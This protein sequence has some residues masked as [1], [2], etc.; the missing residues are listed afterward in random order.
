MNYNN[1]L[2]L[3]KTRIN[4]I[5]GSAQTYCVHYPRLVWLRKTNSGVLWA[6]YQPRGFPVAFVLALCQYQ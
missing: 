3:S 6:A 5:F 4:G 1:Q 2:A